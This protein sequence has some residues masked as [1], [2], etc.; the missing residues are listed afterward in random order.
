MIECGK[1]KSVTS[2]ANSNSLKSGCAPDLVDILEQGVWGHIYS[3]SKA[4]DTL[5]SMK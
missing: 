4:I 2:T 5:L 1:W 3:P